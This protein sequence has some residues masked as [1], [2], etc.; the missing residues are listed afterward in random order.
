V[1]ECLGDAPAI[2]LHVYGGDILD[3]PR[4]MWNP[5]SLEEHP[6]DWTLYQNFARMASSAAAAPG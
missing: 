2:G 6:L 5:E 1:A 4:R 3:L